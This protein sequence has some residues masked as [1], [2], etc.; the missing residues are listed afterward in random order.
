MTERPM[1][2][3]ASAPAPTIEELGPDAAAMAAA[4]ASATMEQPAV[5]AAAP[6]RRPHPMR[7][8]RRL[9]NGLTA[10]G[11][12]ELRGR[13]RGKRAFVIITI[14]LL[15]VAGFAWMVETLMERTLTGGF[16]GTFSVKL[17]ETSVAMADE[18]LAALRRLAAESRRVG[19]GGLFPP[20]GP[21]TPGSSHPP[22]WP[23]AAPLPAGAPAPL[24]VAAPPPRRHPAGRRQP[25]PAR[26]SARNRKPPTA[27]WRPT[28]QD[29][30]GWTAAPRS[31][32]TRRARP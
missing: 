28:P 4:T 12:K 13:M 31:R 27:R 26:R 8:L 5:P 22:R 17:P 10:V 2:D 20:P 15:L 30:S 3:V 6:L 1:D 23:G 32:S 11:V 9:F 16:G 25:A 21:D 19:A 18:K 14:H 24:P 29:R 7:W